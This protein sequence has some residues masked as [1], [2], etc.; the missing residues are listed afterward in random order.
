MRRPLPYISILALFF[1]V[2]PQYLRSQS[3]Q[4]IKNGSATAPAVFSNTGCTYSWTN[5]NPSIGL[6]A[7]GTGN[8]PSFKAINKGSTPI[9][10]TITATPVRTGFA[11][12][13]DFEG[14]QVSVV[15]TATNLVTKTINVGRYPIGVVISPDGSKAYVTN[16]TS[17][18]VSVIS[19]LTNA[20]INTFPCN[21]TPYGV[22]MSPDGNRLYVA[23]GSLNEVT[24]L[25]ALTG[26]I[27]T[28]IPVGLQPSG[29][30]ISPDG[31]TLYVTNSNNNTLSVI[32]TSTYQVTFVL[33]VGNNPYG[34][35][36]SPNGSKLYI[37]NV[38]SRTI[39]VVNTATL[40]IDATIAVGI[41]PVSSCISAD[42]RWV[43]VT[44]S[45]SYGGF[46]SQA[47][48]P[49]GTVSVIDAS[50]NQVVKTIT[51]GKGPDGLAF[52]SYGTKI[53]VANTIDNTIS[54][55]NVGSNTVINTIPVG[56][57]PTPIGNFFAGGTGCGTT[58]VTFTITV[59]PGP[60][61]PVISANTV[62]GTIS[63]CAGSESISPNILRFTVSATNLTD[64]L[65][66]TAPD[67]FEVSFN[68]ASG[69]GNTVSIP[70]MNGDVNDVVIY[71]RSSATA[72][73]GNASGNVTLT[74]TGAAN[75]TIAVNAAI[76]SSPDVSVPK[77]QIV[78][79]GRPT[80][81]VS[82][83]GTGSSYTWTNDTPGI[84][85]AA[86]GT[87]NIPSF[88]AINKGSSPVTATIQVTALPK[89]S[90]FAYIPN[91]SDNTVAVVNTTTNQVTNVIKAGIQPYG[92]SVSPDGGRVYITNVQ[93][94]TVSV[95]NTTTNTLVGTIQVGS[96]PGGV[97]VS[98][99]GSTL[100]VSNGT[101]VSAINTATFQIIANILIGRYPGMLAISPDG[102]KLYVTNSYG[103]TNNK[104]DLYVINTITNKIDA[105]IETGT[106]SNGVV[107]TPDG[108]EVFVA[109]T[110]SNDVS[111]IN[112]STNKVVAT[113]PVSTGPWGICI[114]P[115]GRHVYVSDSGDNM[116]ALAPGMV[117]VIDVATNK[118]VATIPVGKY[119]IGISITPD[120]GYVY[121][122]NDFGG[123]GNGNVSII[124]TGTN[125]VTAT[126]GTGTNPIAIGNFIA[127]LPI[128]SSV[129]VNFTITVNPAA[130]PVD[131]GTPGSIVI[132]N[133]FTPN[134]DGI[135]DI[136]NIKNLN[137]Y[138]N[139]TVQIFDRWGQKIYSSIGYGM[140]WDGTYRGAAV[141]GGTYY[142]II[143]LKNST[144]PLAGFVAVIR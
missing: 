135:N 33:T 64:E 34:I 32:N 136:W 55:I 1:F 140:P 95:I 13:T 9:T 37:A 86:S 25:N 30:A 139:C 123:N 71:V 8:I 84:G 48:F 109:N 42:G 110:F 70:P 26:A 87:G 99:D 120:G 59:E 68:E 106:N 15:D 72:A 141:P 82:F 61:T 112:T 51:V 131:P 100:Y 35:T 50:I 3:N 29:L 6:Q 105:T 46:G 10:A 4:D 28:A 44:N 132:P 19:T 45:D 14:G 63:A 91:A 41:G 79:N 138:S 137:T 43:Y 104:S 39:T 73:S 119:P 127:N 69:Y 47:N 57:S 76:N 125:K 53:Y 62:Q 23:N 144:P 88:T 24:I 38:I 92:V 83:S 102:K 52:N 124:N 134:G 111:V 93:S 129:P 115:D 97:C 49:P 60:P 40:T 94:N 18:T 58:P 22:V 121:V 2:L 114:S 80:K 107:V 117:S 130:P 128:C 101:L 11:Y 56:S 12:V 67:G 75:Q 108:S 143:D 20:V 16:D 89:S 77:D 74:S 113:I 7:T 85:L 31:G 36:I 116:S 81:T 66:A 118:V 122:A 126:I 27:I 21:K 65:V 78:D 54:V 142:Y 103:D 98:P 133:T 90:Q 96:E 17:G 5:D